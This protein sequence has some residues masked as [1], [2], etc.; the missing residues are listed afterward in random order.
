MSVVTRQKNKGSSDFGQRL[1]LLCQSHQPHLNFQ[2]TSIFLKHF[3]FLSHRKEKKPKP[4]SQIFQTRTTAQSDAVSS[5]S[6]LRQLQTTPCQL[7]PLS[8]YSRANAHQNVVDFAAAIGNNI[9][10]F[11]R[12]QESSTSHDTKSWKLNA[13]NI[14]EKTLSRKTQVYDVWRI[15]TDLF[16]YFRYF[17]LLHYQAK[18]EKSKIIPLM[19]SS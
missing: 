12:K 8:R 5:F 15:K 1:K 17:P 18:I 2:P 6:L 13:S 10:S 3:G 14:R 19:I 11:E 4:E 9:G 7:L 16:M